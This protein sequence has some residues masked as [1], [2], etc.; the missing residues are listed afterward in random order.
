[1]FKSIII[2][3]A[4]VLASSTAGAQTESASR[5]TA[6]IAL[7][8]DTLELRYQGGADVREAPRSRT[9]AGFLLTED[10]DIVIDAGLLIPANLQLGPLSMQFGPR[11]YAALLDE[12]NNDIFT[13]S[14]GAEL[15]FDINRNR[16]LALTGKAYYA[17]DILTFGS[18]DNLID[19]SA[20]AEFKATGDL[21]VFAGMR[22]FELDLVDGGGENTLMEEVFVGLG[23]QF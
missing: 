6:E 16:G 15:R 17:P 22:W 13:L 12:E 8:N 11:A 1:M 7:S 21:L 10:R 2:I 4:C 18:A 9:T 3:A 23:W 14:V 20:R 5:R 19:L